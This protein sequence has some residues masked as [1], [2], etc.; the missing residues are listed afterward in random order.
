MQKARRNLFSKYHWLC[1]T[2][3]KD[4]AQN[5]VLPTRIRVMRIFCLSGCTSTVVVTVQLCTRIIWKVLKCA[6]VWTSLSEIL[7][8]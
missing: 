3:N 6:C 2:Q 4:K 8:Y 7:V 5:F 1:N